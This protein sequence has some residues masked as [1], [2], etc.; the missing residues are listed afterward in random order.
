MKKTLYL[1]L[2]LV[3]GFSA[4]LKAQE[5]S[6][7][8]SIKSQVLENKVPGAT[9]APPKQANAAKSK[10][11]EGSSLGKQMKDGKEEGMKYN[12]SSAP[13][14]PTGISNEKDG[15][16]PSDM[17]AFK[18]KNPKTVSETTKPKEKDN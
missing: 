18:A 6:T 1:V 17:E 5:Y 16:L 9:Y 3:L 14:N 13:K 15:T 7:E 2:T 12:T 11:F 4:S 8:K 10:G